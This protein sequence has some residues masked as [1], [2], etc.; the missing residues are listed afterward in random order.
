MMSH[1]V[2]QYP[3]RCQVVQAWDAVGRYIS[4]V[5]THFDSAT[6]LGLA[7][8]RARLNAGLTQE[9]LGNKLA[10]TSK[11]IGRWEAGDTSSL[12]ESPEA[13]FAVAAQVAAATGDLTLIGIT[14]PE[15]ESEL[16]SLR[17]ELNDLHDE[18]RQLAELLGQ[19]PGLPNE[20]R[21]RLLERSEPT[22]L[23]PATRPLEDR[24]R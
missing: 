10:T 14:G 3:F 16:R 5:G 12:G 8:K 1:T 11:R 9:G 22:H 21:R 13:Q 20:G 24:G 17:R 19:V 7:I 4:P 18:V 6:D 23:Q 15:K 2:P